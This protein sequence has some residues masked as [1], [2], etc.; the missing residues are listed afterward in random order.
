MKI[1]DRLKMLDLYGPFKFAQSFSNV[2]A[3]IG[4]LFFGF[5]FVLANWSLNPIEDLLYVRSAGFILPANHV[6][7]A[8]A[9]VGT[10]FY[11][12]A[13]YYDHA[14]RWLFLVFSTVSIHEY[15]LDGLSIPSMILAHTLSYTITFRWWFWLTFFLVPA[16]VLANKEQRKIQFRIALFCL[17]YIGG[18]ILAAE[19]FNI[20]TYTILAFVPGPAYHEFL[21]NF[22]EVTSWIIPALLWFTYKG[23]DPESIRYNK[24]ARG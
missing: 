17:V 24:G 3:L 14:I 11:F 21:P 20:D 22:F 16:V 19:A 15:I 7:S 8:F 13:K 10:A 1:S 5:N 23:V 9:I 12:A 4:I 18:W 2:I 6:S